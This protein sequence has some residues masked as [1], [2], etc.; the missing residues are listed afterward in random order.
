M[1]T[2][3]AYIRDANQMLSPGG[4]QLVEEQGPCARGVTFSLWLHYGWN[5]WPVVLAQPRRITRQIAQA[6][7]EQGIRG[8]LVQHEEAKVYTA[9]VASEGDDIDCVG[10]RE[11]L[12]RLDSG[13]W[14]VID[15]RPYI[16]SWAYPAPAGASEGYV[17]R[18]EQ[19][20]VVYRMLFGSLHLSEVRGGRWIIQQR[21]Y[22]ASDYVDVPEVLPEGTIALHFKRTGPGRVQPAREGAVS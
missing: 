8:L 13:L 19:V 22:E 11:A 18:S 3:P 20:P 14:E 9:G 6:V 7:L 4:W 17:V 12:L 10:L 2:Q 16:K 21:S 1:S 5:R 15:S